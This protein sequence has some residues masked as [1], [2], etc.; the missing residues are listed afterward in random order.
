MSDKPS[1]VSINHASK[2][3]KYEEDYANDVLRQEISM[4]QTIMV[5]FPNL[6]GIVFSD[7]NL[8]VSLNLGI[9]IIF[10]PGHSVVFL[11]GCIGYKH[12]TIT[13]ST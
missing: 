10:K 13:K 7:V 9:F 1:Y 12:F 6:D 4:L 5:K 8:E 3:W 11:C 2:D